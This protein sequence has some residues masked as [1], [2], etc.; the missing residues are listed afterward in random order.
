[1]K[2]RIIAGALFFL[3]SFFGTP[4]SADFLGVITADNVEVIEDCD[5]STTNVIGTL[6]EGE[7][8]PVID[9]LGGYC[10]IGYENNTALVKSE[11]V[12]TD[13]T[14]VD[15][16]TK[17]ALLGILVTKYAKNFTGVPYVYGGSTPSGFDC[18]GFVK[19]IYSRFGISLPRVS[20]SQLRSGM[21]VDK[22]DLKEGDLL[23]FRGGG[24]VGIYVGNGEYIHA[25]RTGRSV[26]VEPLTRSL[27]AARRIVF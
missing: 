1:M 21:P 25:P 4:A 14:T 24:H 18:S 7:S 3:L 19:Y 6:H 22:N 15:E 16:Y 2:K 23:F 8:V 11:Y 26:S 13:K 20:Y 5:Y 17:Y 27:Y 10:R 9:M 12:A